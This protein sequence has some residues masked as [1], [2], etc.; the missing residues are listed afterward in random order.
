MSHQPEMLL[1]TAEAAKFL[2]MAPRSLANRRTKRQGPPYVAIGRP[3]YRMCELLSWL[4]A[5]SVHPAVPAN[6]RRTT[7]TGIANA[8]RL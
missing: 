2:R 7:S 5:N 6:G 1:T 3:R 8:G 4:A